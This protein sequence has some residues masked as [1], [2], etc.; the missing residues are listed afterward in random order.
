[1]ASMDSMV[2][3]SRLKKVD[4]CL[5]NDRRYYLNGS[6]LLVFSSFYFYFLIF[7]LSLFFFL[8]LPSSKLKKK[9]I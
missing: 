5:S 4:V 9:C 6:S 2:Y 1:M 8:T 7:S 3:A